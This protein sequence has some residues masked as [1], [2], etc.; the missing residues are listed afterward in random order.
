MF[1][2]LGAYLIC[3][4][5]ALLGHELSNYWISLILLGLGWNFLFI[6]GTTLLPYVYRPQERFQVQAVNDFIVFG[7]QAFAAVSAG[8]FVFTWGWETLL[9]VT[10]PIIFL[11]M[12]VLAKWGPARNP[13]PVKI[14]VSSTEK[15]IKN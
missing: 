4:V 12:I 14:P 9:L 6:G 11:Q 1:T 15:D 2:G 13:E 10:L 3:I 7:T 8:W 5:I